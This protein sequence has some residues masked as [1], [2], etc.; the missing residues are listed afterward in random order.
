MRV[1]VAHGRCLHPTD[2]PQGLS[3]AS[4]QVLADEEASSRRRASTCSSAACWA[5][6]VSSLKERTNSA[7]SS[8]RMRLR[9]SASRMRVLEQRSRHRR[10]IGPVAVNDLDLVPRCPWPAY[11]TTAVPRRGVRQSC[12]AGTSQASKLLWLPRL[13][14]HPLDQPPRAVE[15]LVPRGP[16]PSR[17]WPAQVLKLQLGNG[18]RSR[19]AKARTL[20]PVVMATSGDCLRHYWYLRQVPQDDRA[21]LKHAS[22]PAVPCSPKAMSPCAI[23]AGAERYS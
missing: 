9:R 10:V 7:T 22:I 18:A 16:G 20:N 2:I 4:P 14:P 11:A 5:R 15:R 1:P 12:C 13:D 6:L 19:T 8:G 3:R 17:I 23:G 21:G